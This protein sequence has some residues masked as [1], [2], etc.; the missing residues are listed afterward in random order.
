MESS[1]PWT[2]FCSIMQARA[3]KNL[4]LCMECCVEAVGNKTS[5][6]DRQTDRQ[7]GRQALS[8]GDMES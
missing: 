8:L 4:R 3:I 6:A 2:G 5:K 1:G 7:A